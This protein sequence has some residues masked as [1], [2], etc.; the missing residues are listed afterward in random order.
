MNT[1]PEGYLILI[2]LYKQVFYPNPFFLANDV[3][4]A[5]KEISNGLTLSFTE[6][7]GTAFTK[8]F[9]SRSGSN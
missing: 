2:E 5:K 7:P 3:Q 9:E 1:V 8:E 4:Y 6:A